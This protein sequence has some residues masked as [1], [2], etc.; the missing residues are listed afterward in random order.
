MLLVPPDIIQMVDLWKNKDSKF[1]KMV[2][3][4]INCIVR[5]LER[6]LDCKI[7]IEAILA[8]NLSQVLRGLSLWLLQYFGQN[9]QV[10]SYT[11]H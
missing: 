9:T 1:Q 3:G 7:I 10:H 4:H 5:R 11:T 2:I 6:V 8:C